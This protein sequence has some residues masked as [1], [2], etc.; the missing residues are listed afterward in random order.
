MLIPTRLGGWLQPLRFVSS[1]EVHLGKALQTV[2]ALFLNAAVA[3]CMDP[4][5]K[6][7]LLSLSE[8]L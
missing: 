3:R 7:H 6:G 8:E 2:G 4:F 5:K 1:L